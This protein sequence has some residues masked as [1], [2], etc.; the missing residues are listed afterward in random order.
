M[1]DETRA[2]AGKGDDPDGSNF[3]CDQPLGALRSAYP[4]TWRKIVERAGRQATVFPAGMN[5]AA[6]PAFR[7]VVDGDD[8]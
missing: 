4:E 5:P 3:A 6:E 8:A 2:K 1:G 7:Y